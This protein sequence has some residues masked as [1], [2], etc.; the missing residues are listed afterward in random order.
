MSGQCQS[1]LGICLEC[2]SPINCT[3]CNTPLIFHQDGPNGIGQCL[4]ECP[5]SYFLDAGA[6]KCL[7]CRPECLSCE[8]D[9]SCTL[10][11]DWKAQY[12]GQC[13]DS[14]PNQMYPLSGV[15]EACSAPCFNCSGA[16]TCTSCVNNSY[17][18]VGGA[19]CILGEICP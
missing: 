19:Q 14:C 9:S 10:C 15:C 13:L 7:A 5:P 18:L 12:Q 1:C 16:Y 8:N 4:S 6:L 11:R 17:L 2:T 3:S